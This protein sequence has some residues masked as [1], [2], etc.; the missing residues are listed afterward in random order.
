[1]SNDD[2]T[3]L[4][5][6]TAESPII[7]KAPPVDVVPINDETVFGKLNGNEAETMESIEGFMKHIHEQGNF[8][9]QS[10]KRTHDSNFTYKDSIKKVNENVPSTSKEETLKD[11]CK[12]P[13]KTGPKSKIDPTSRKSTILL[14]SPSFENALSSVVTKVYKIPKLS[15]PNVSSKAVSPVLEISKNKKVEPR[16]RSKRRISSSSTNSSKLDEP[17]EKKLKPKKRNVVLDSEASREDKKVVKSPVKSKIVNIK[18]KESNSIAKSVDKDVKRKKKHGDKLKTLVGKLPD[19][20]TDVPETSEL[21]LSLENLVGKNGLKKMKS[22][23]VN[24]TDAIIKTTTSTN[25]EETVELAVLESSST[26]EKQKP[27]VEKTAKRT[28]PNLENNK[29]VKKQKMIEEICNNAIKEEKKISPKNK[30]K[31][32]NELERLNADIDNMFIRDAVMKA[33]GKRACTMK[34]NDEISLSNNENMSQIKRCSVVLHRLELNMEDNSYNIHNFPLQNISANVTVV[35]ALDSAKSSI[36][37]VTDKVVVAKKPKLKKKTKKNKP[38]TPWTRLACKKLELRDE[39]WEDVEDDQEGSKSSS[40]VVVMEQNV[41]V[42]AEN[43]KNVADTAENIKNVNEL[44]DKVVTESTTNIEPDITKQVQVSISNSTE[45]ATSSISTNKVKDTHS[46]SACKLFIIPFKKVFNLS[47]SI[48]NCGTVYKC[49]CGDCKFQTLIKTAFIGHLNENHKS[50]PWNG[51][52]DICHKIEQIEKEGEL[53]KLFIVDEYI[54]MFKK[55]I[56]HE[57]PVTTGEI[58]Q[59]AGNSKDKLGFVNSPTFMPKI[60]VGTSSYINNTKKIGGSIVGK[61]I[62]M[63]KVPMNYIMTTN[64][65]TETKVSGPKEKSVENCVPTPKPAL[66]PMTIRPTVIKAPASTSWTQTVINAPKELSPTIIHVKPVPEN[67][68]YVIYDNKSN[69]TLRPWL[70]AHPVLKSRQLCKEMLSEICL[71]AKFKCMATTCSYYTNDEK[72]FRKHLKAHS[73]FQPTDKSNFSMCA[74]CPFLGSG[75]DSLVV[76]IKSVHKYD[77]FQCPYCFYRTVVD[78]NVLTH[79]DLFHKMKPKS[80]IE[81]NLTQVKN[82]VTELETIKKTRAN[83]VPPIV[84]VCKYK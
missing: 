73:Q 30:Y 19:S 11:V 64:Q 59:N 9:Q 56:S 61:M 65:K 22:I 41:A 32:K 66:I 18:A 71:V 21:I 14:P 15:K 39:E 3:Q 35:K 8:F 12:S 44:V 34:T 36:E 74:Y 45:I 53:E 47:Y 5:V 10:S 29:S 69:E 17:T 38:R 13:K 43:I 25:V 49:S 16:A 48:L 58:L 78:F 68:T 52:C 50:V 67:M 24:S 31:K 46:I 51:Y 7:H 70:S 26:V 28:L 72:Y 83:Y 37:L 79:M 40:P 33:N 4:L 55:H 2:I 27:S 57:P 60:T 81:C 42:T 63:V 80:I 6:E 23:F 54:H 77:R 82:Y 62:P 76:H 1:M 84:C 75:I 20:V